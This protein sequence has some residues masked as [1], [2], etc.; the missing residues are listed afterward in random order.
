MIRTN[1]VP[2]QA[3]ALLC[4]LTSVTA[5]APLASAQTDRDSDG[6]SRSR[7]LRRFRPRLPDEHERNHPLVKAAFKDVVAPTSPSTVRVLSDGIQTALGTI[8]RSD[9]YI[10][11]K[12]SELDGKIQCYFGNGHRL[13]AE[14]VSV[15]AE[16]DLALLHVEARGL[17]SVRWSEGGE[18]PVGSWL[19]SPNVEETP[20]AIGIMSAPSRTIPKPRAVLGIRLE[21]APQGPRV[22]SVIS[23]SAAAKAGLKAGDVIK[24]IDG[25]DLANRDQLIEAIGRRGPGDRVKLSVLRE[26]KIQSVTA[27]LGDFSHVGNQQQADLMDSLGG[28]L[29]R[30][31]YGFSSVLQH[32]S[33]LRPRDCG[34][35]VVNLD[36]EVIGVNIARA[37]RVA[38]YALPAP[39]VKHVLNE[40]LKNELTEVARGEALE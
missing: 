14:I 10:L 7:F 2:W 34:G 33:V 32:D 37:S 3:L 23:N 12:A 39:Y 21:N 17:P 25:V 6:R 28:P 4:V 11:T 8:V 15:H 35:P 18:P 9:G 16:S 30:R 19:A 40:L 27:T 13:D 29:S 20:T 24:N 22:G 1:H 31:R 38:S 36:G 26:G 5:L